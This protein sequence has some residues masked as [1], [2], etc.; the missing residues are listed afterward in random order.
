MVEQHTTD[1]D[2]PAGIVADFADGTCIVSVAGDDRSHVYR[3][4]RHGEVVAE[5]CTLIGITRSVF[6]AVE[7]RHR[8]RR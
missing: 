6:Q 4:V 2:D 1:L 7:A 8:R 3:Y 5:A